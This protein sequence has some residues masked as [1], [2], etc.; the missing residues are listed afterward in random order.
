MN[1]DELKAVWQSQT[2]P[3]RLTIDADVLLQQLQRNK[4]SFER[5]VFW[6]YFRE[7]GVSLVMVPVWIWLGLRYD[8]PWTWYLSIPALLWIAGFMVVGRIRQRRRQP[9]PADP[10]RACVEQSLAQ[11]EHLIWLARNV[12]WW[13]LLPPTVA[14]AAF[15]GHIAWMV[16]DVGWLGELVVAGMFVVAGL[17]LGG[18]YWLNQEAIRNELAPRR[19]ELRALIASLDNTNH[20]GIFPEHGARSARPSASSKWS[21][22][23]QIFL[24]CF[25]LAAIAL[26]I[27]DLWKEGHWE[28]SKMS[29][30]EG[31]TAAGDADGFQI[32]S[33]QYGGEGKWVDVT[34]KVRARVHDGVL[35]IKASNEIAGDPAYGILK[36]LRVK[37]RFKG[38]EQQTECAEGQVLHLP[39]PFKIAADQDKLMQFAATCPGQIGFYGKNLNTSQTVELNAD[40]P[41]CMASMVKIFVLLEC[42]RESQGGNLDLKETLTVNRPA[43]DSEQWTIEKAMFMMIAAS[44]NEATDALAKRLGYDQVNALPKELGIQGLSEEILPEPGVLEEVLDK[45]IYSRSKLADQL[46]P[47]HGTARAMTAYFELLHQE[48]LISPAVSRK[49][50]EQFEKAPMGFAPNAKQSGFNCIGKGGSILWIR[51]FRKHYNMVGWVGLATKDQTAIAFCIWSEWFPTDDDAIRLDWLYTLSDSIINVLNRDAL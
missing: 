49:V 47:Q 28:E 30:R 51:L 9:K 22:V 7:V 10:L 11:V 8:L 16:R 35:V 13:Y 1:P 33:A 41:A 32:L 4:K 19:Q 15:F 46:L 6:C 24:I 17:I 18:V 20:A 27:R 42:V 26:F 44:D 3:R 5:T 2:S 48:K 36:V 40:Q 37:Y 45:R 34:R 25:I 50:L 39:E 14:I 31:S 43:A 38:V 12:L 29:L 21:K 23:L